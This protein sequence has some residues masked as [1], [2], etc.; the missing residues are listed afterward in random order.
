MTIVDETCIAQSIGVIITKSDIFV[1]LIQKT[2]KIGATDS[3]LITN[4]D[5]WHWHLKEIIKIVIS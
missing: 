4:G 2:F 1:A 5:C 3:V